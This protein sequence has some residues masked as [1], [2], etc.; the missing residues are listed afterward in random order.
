MFAL[1]SETTP[2]GKGDS[3]PER[4][5]CFLPPASAWKLT[6]LACSNPHSIVVDAIRLDN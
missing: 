6:F 5:R 2:I 1:D 3:H 4:L